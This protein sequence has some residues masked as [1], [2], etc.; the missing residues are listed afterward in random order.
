M[1]PAEFTIPTCAVARAS[2]SAHIVIASTDPWRISGAC[3]ASAWRIG[4]AAN[5]VLAGYVD[6]AVRDAVMSLAAFHARASHRGAPA[7]A[8]VR[9]QRRRPAAAAPSDR[10][11]GPFQ[12]E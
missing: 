6:V 9:R 5:L 8:G 11:S 3:V 12:N 1:R 7:G 4:V 2:S 10:V